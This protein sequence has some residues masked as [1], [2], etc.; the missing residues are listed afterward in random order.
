MAQY[1]ELPTTTRLAILAL[2]IGIFSLFTYSMIVQFLSVI[3]SYP[4]VTGIINVALY[5]SVFFTL[6]RT[7]RGPYFYALLVL[8][9]FTIYNIV[10]LVFLY[11]D[12][13]STPGFSI[14]WPSIHYAFFL[15]AFV[16]AVLPQSWNFYSE[17][18]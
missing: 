10:S 1:G 12:G 4:A 5:W 9:P 3:D 6:K 15:I 11:N 17:S 7:Q 2:C 14:I 16:L 13:V 18:T 8:G